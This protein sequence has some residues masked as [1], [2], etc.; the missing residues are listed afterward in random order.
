MRS[1]HPSLCQPTTVNH[2]N[3]CQRTCDGTNRHLGNQACV[4]RI[5]SR[6]L[7]RSAMAPSLAPALVSGIASWLEILGRTLTRYCSRSDPSGGAS[8]PTPAQSRTLY[9]ILL[10]VADGWTWTVIPPAGWA[11]GFKVRPT[12]MPL[13]A[14]KT[15]QVQACAERQ[16]DGAEMSETSTERMVTQVLDMRGCDQVGTKKTATEPSYP[17]RP[18]SS[19]RRK[20]SS[21][22]YVTRHRLTP[23]LPF[24]SR[25]CF[26]SDS[27]LRPWSFDP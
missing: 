16:W 12:A 18:P 4:W 25:P 9:D 20:V 21:A 6:A 7:P 19:K 14:S 26:V 2:R 17:H 27:C 8:T 10:G 5:P 11:V 23:N 13:S 24:L 22:R 1:W 3:G 15:K